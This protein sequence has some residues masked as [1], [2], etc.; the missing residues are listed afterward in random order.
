MRFL[1][2]TSYAG[3][4][5]TVAL[6][7]VGLIRSIRILIVVVFPAPL[8]PRNPNTDPRGTEIERLSK[9]FGPRENQ[10]R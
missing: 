9:A 4:P 5:S 2:S 3:F 6:P 8:G 10:W 7:S 1:T